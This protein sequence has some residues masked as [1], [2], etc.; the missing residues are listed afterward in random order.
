MYMNILA[1]MA[2]KSLTRKEVAKQ[3]NLSEAS[4][5]KKIQGENEF[6]MSE[7]EILLSL[8]GDVTFEYL[9]AK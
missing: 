4:F 9:F 3:L 7:V 1:E 2:R 5:R 8:F 6:K